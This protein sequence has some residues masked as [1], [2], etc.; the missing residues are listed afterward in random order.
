MQL[1]A[2][3]DTFFKESKK[4]AVHNLSLIVSAYPGGVAV[5]AGDLTQHECAFAVAQLYVV[6]LLEPEGSH[7]M[8]G[9]FPLD[10]GRSAQ[11]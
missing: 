10:V 1:P 11:R 9:F 8:L 6:S 3:P 7:S 5:D 2:L 4:A